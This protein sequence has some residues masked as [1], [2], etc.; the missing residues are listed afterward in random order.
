MDST[1]PTGSRRVEIAGITK[2][3][4]INLTVCKVATAAPTPYS[5][6]IRLIAMVP[7]GAEPNRAIIFSTPKNLLINSPTNKPVVKSMKVINNAGFQSDCS[8]A[9]VSLLIPVPI[10]VPIHIPSTVFVPKGQAATSSFPLTLNKPAPNIAPNSDAAG[11]PVSSRR[12]PKAAPAR[13]YIIKVING[14][15][16][17]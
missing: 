15:I 16:R 10:T 2:R 4:V 13:R 7:P 6:P 14:G 12:E 9:N 3:S 17:I 5:A 8:S 11:M 1:A